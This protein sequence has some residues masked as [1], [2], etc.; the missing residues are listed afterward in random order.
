MLERKVPSTHMYSEI[1]PQLCG[2]FDTQSVM[3][4]LLISFFGIDQSQTVKHVNCSDHF[5]EWTQHK[6]YIPSKHLH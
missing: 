4:M 3:M 2:H 1:T 5:L 6:Q